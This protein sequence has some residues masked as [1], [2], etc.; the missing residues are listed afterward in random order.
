M[1]VAYAHFF[2]S[3]RCST[4]LYSLSERKKTFNTERFRVFMMHHQAALLPAFQMQSTLQNK[5]CGSAFWQEQTA[6]RATLST[7]LYISVAQLMDPVSG[8]LFFV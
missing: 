4:E 2:L 1:R 7:E 8:S 6:K 5:I 3:D